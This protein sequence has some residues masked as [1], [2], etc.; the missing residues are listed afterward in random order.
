MKS[1]SF[2]ISTAQQYTLCNLILQPN[3]LQ[4]L[5]DNLM[6]WKGSYYMPHNIEPEGLIFN[7]EDKKPFF[8]GNETKWGQSKLMCRGLLISLWQW[9]I[10]IYQ[11]LEKWDLNQKGTYTLHIM[12]IGLDA[13][14]RK[15]IVF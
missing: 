2:I 9:M 6:V 3:E 15:F 13:Y 4:E 7:S 8:P 14:L 12:G 11:I 5:C 10:Y 1:Y